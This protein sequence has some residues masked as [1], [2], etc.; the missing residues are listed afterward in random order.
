MEIYLLKTAEKREGRGE[1]KVA[2]T[3]LVME[4]SEKQKLQKLKGGKREDH[5]YGAALC[6]L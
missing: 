3:C 6:G 4:A 5:V 1:E 2:G